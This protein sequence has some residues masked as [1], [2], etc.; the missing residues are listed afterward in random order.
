MA[1]LQSPDHR[2]ATDASASAHALLRLV[3][4]SLTDVAP[5][6]H[7]L[8]RRCGACGG[9]HGKPV[10]DHPTLH[11]SLAGTRHVVAVVV[12]PGQ[13]V[14]IDVERVRST[15]FHGFDAVALA[16]G[17]R[18]RS[19]RGR[20]RAWTRKEALLKATGEGLTVAPSSVDVR[21]DSIG[22]TRQA[23]LYDVRIGPGLAGAVAV[24]GLRRPTLRTHRVALPS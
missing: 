10:L 16:P 11:V 2:P 5:Q 17:E 14:G 23:Q 12:G 9:E 1:H 8:T 7:V 22:G 21:R 20:A 19:L 4:S 3:L 15:G 18:A 6:D 13:P 24:L